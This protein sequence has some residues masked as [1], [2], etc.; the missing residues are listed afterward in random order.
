MR[1]GESGGKE[2]KGIEVLFILKILTIHL[3]KKYISYV[4]LKDTFFFNSDFS[5][6]QGA[7]GDF[8]DAW[9]KKI[10]EL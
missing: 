5:C 2:Q 3:T 4:L 6:P 8:R 10:H 9:L 7:H 1:L